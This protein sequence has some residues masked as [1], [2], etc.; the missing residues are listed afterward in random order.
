[1]RTL[2]LIGRGS[3]LSVIQLEK[4]RAKIL[5]KFPE[6]GVQIITRESRGDALQ[7]IPLQTVEGSD[8]FTQDIFDALNSGEADIAVHS[9]KD[10]SSDH[11][12][13]H[14]HFAVIDRDD[15]RDI[16]IF[17]LGI[18][19]KLRRGEK[20][21]IGTCSPRREE[22][23]TIFLKEALPQ[24]GSFSIETRPIRGNVDTRLRKL[25]R[26]EYDGIILATAGLNRLLESEKDR[27]VI[28]ELLFGKKLMLLPLIECVPA[29]CQGAIVAEC[30]VANE[31]AAQV[32]NEINNTGVYADCV[33]EKRK[34][35]QYGKGCIQKFGVT[36]VK[37]ASG[38]FLYAA[39]V[40]SAENKFVHWD[41]LPQ[42]S[43][44]D[45][46]LFSATDHM[47]SFF[48]YEWLDVHAI[49]H[50]VVFIANHKAIQHLDVQLLRNKTVI[51][52]G[53]RTWF[54]LAKQGYWVTA[55]ADGLGLRVLLPSLKMPVLNIPV[56]E[57]CIVTHEE[58]ADR[59]RGK[60]IAAIG[61]YRLKT[62]V[63]PEFKKRIQEADH[64]FWTSIS[65]F[66]VYGRF[67]NE[68]AIHLSAG[69]ET[70][71]YLKEQNVKQLIFPT[72]KSF[73]QWRRTFTR[74]RSVA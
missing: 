40:D 43:L 57:L 60:G 7:D 22:M 25:D 35:L 74:Q 16:A 36:T 61:T 66:Q 69:G 24:L 20:V 51:A 67:A 17:Q 49:P 39:G 46:T 71:E 47:K 19:E 55:S 68:S 4:V 1:M 72:I 29:P 32:L 5:E 38:N 3:R 65:Q 28:A 23:A 15:T 12:F 45:I 14:N 50:P 70:A 41:H 9:L 48:G 26:G 27:A 52:A 63:N 11:F 8:F 53:S 34:G 54:E 33:A 64:I 21:I 42:P 31:W 6:V 59:W 37:I 58:A 18:E 62:E 44:N 10:M 2:K 30:I 73:E 13:G 56:S